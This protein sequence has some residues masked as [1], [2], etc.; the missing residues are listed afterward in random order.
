VSNATASFGAGHCGDGDVTG[1]NT[2]LAGGSQAGEEAKVGAE[3]AANAFRITTG[4]TSGEG[5][6]AGPEG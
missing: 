5:P 6:A 3:P 4:G 2:G 1:C